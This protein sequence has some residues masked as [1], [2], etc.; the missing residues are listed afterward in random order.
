MPGAY[1]AAP[2]TLS[3]DLATVSRFLQNPENIRRRLR[4]FRDLRS[5]SDQLLTGRLRSQGGA[6]LYEQSEPF[7]TD[8]PVE[9]VSPGANYPYANLPVGT[10]GIA[11]V[12]KWGQK[13]FLSD[14]EILRSSLSNVI[15]RALRKVVN[16]VIKQVDAV[17][18]SAIASGVT[19][20]Q[21][22]IAAWDAATTV[23]AP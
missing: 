9:Q 15:D 22:V 7:V 4:D 19:Q 5:V 21:A 23:H 16:S 1:P 2:P 11:A 12:A 17:T 13:T 20:T 18:M 6:V 10:A 8:R 3:G 14:E